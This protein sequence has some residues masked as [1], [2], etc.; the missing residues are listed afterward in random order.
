MTESEW[1]ACTDPKP[2]LEVLRGQASDRKLRLFAVTCCRRAWET[3][4][5]PEESRETH[6]AVLVAERV[7]EGLIG[8]GHLRDER[9]KIGGVGS[10]SS[11]TYI[12]NAMSALVK[13]SPAEAAGGAAICAAYCLALIRVGDRLESPEDKAVMIEA[14]EAEHWVQAALVRDIFGDPFRP[15]AIDPAWLVPCVVSLALTIYEDR[16]FDRMPELAAALEEAGCHDAEV[17]AH[18]RRPGLHV[19]GCWVVDAILRKS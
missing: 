15:V 2:M 7:A 11:T 10:F 18:C 16:A 5:G 19:R 4:C 17:L 14:K 8:E 9:S 13:N 1:L 3:S 6:P 12:S